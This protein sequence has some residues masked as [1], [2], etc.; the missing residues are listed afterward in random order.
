M[1]KQKVIYINKLTSQELLDLLNQLLFAGS[2]CKN[3]ARD[4]IIRRQKLIANTIHNNYPSVWKSEGLSHRL[5]EIKTG[6]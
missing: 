6:L 2:F 5:H 4:E 3:A 1:K